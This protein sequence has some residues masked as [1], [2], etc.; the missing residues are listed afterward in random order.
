MT[1]L[2]VPL[3]LAAVAVC[4]V[5]RR[6]DVYAALADG[7]RSGGKILLSVFPNLVALLTAVAMLRASG[8]R[9]IPS[10]NPFVPGAAGLVLAGAVLKDLM[11]ME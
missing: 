3:L 10:S 6:V 11:G 1:A 4:G 2:L 8:K 7:A 5:V 9:Q